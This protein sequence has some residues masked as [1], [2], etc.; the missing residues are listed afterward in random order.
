V[1]LTEAAERA[2]VAPAT[3]RRWIRSAFV[4]VARQRREEAQ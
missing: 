4:F 3:L 2:E 1:T